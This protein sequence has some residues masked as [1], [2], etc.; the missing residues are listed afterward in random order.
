MNNQ[1]KLIELL[2]EKMLAHRATK[3][4]CWKLGDKTNAHHQEGREFG[5][6]TAI[7]ILSELDTPPV[8]TIKP[9]D[10]VKYKPNSEL[11]LGEVRG[12]DVY[13]KFEKYG[14]ASRISPGD[15]EVVE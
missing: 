10:K 15:L 5:L 7:D 1:V 6:Q 14:L 4:R 9:G 11:G 12:I 2:T 13:V 3:E 8:P